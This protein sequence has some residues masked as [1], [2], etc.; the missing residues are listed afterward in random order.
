MKGLVAC[1]SSGTVRDAFR[2]LGHDFISADL[3]PTEAE[4]P[5]YKGDALRLKSFDF[6]FIG[7]HPPCTYLT[8]AGVWALY[9]KDG[10][11][12]EE[13]WIQMEQA[14]N[15]FRQFINWMTQKNIKGYIENPVPHKYAREGFHSVLTGE[16]VEGIGKYTQTIQPY[17]FGECESKRTCLWLFN[18][19]PLRPTYRQPGRLVWHKGKLSEKFNNQTNSGQNRLGP[20]TDRWKIRSKTYQGIADA[21]AEQ[22][23]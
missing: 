12:N 3:L 11:K 6:D 9:N 14:V 7:A 21:M 10:S 1:E 5:H 15:F 8:N 2:K 19:P 4:G 23:T 22:W 16:W 20:S 13:R 17:Q 18:L